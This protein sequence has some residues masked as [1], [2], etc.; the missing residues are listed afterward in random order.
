VITPRISFCVSLFGRCGRSEDVIYLDNSATTPLSPTVREAMMP[1]LDA[2]FGNASSV[3]TLGNRARVAI[4]EAREI[5]ARSIGAAPREITFT[6]SGTEA[7]NSALKGRYFHLLSSGLAASE[8]ELVTDYAEHHSVLHPVD[9]LRQLG[10]TARYLN[11]DA[12]GHVELDALR[13]VLGERTQI[14]SVTHVNNEVGAIND[15]LEVIRIVREL[16]PNAL[17]HIDAVQSLGK[18]PIDVREMQVDLLTIS[19][20]KIHGPKGIGALYTRGS[21]EW[22]PLIHGGAQERNRRAGTESAALAVGFAAAIKELDVECSNTLQELRRHLLD[23]LSKIPGIVMNSATGDTC[24]PSIVNFSFVPEILA[25]LDTDA[26]LIRF[27]LEGI[28]ISN[29]SACTSGSLQPSHVLL[30]MGK[31]S[32]VASKSIRVSFSKHNTTA[33]IDRFISVLKGILR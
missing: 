29:G 32:E 14:V 30:A 9:F 13:G 12:T 3:Y 7:N 22:E 26:L 21:V 23:A 19:A 5:V 33:E 25:R 16:A 1:Y 18:L 17:V 2:E 10:A 8:I 11:V 6:S 24:S 20:H 31:T 27:D 15:P 28:A 4:E